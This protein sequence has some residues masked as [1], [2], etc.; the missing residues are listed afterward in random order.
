MSH[1]YSDTFFDYIDASARASATHVTTLLYP[2][3]RPASVIDMG[4]GR[5]V[6]L[7]A[8]RRAGANEVLG[9]DGD[10]VD[11]RTLEI[12]RD[13]FL[14]A[15]LTQP[16]RTGRRFDLAQSL[17]VGEHLPACAAETLVESLTTASDRVLFSA[18]VVGQ[19]GEFHINEQPLS[20]WQ[21]LFDARGYRA[22]DCL[23]PHLQH[24]RSV[25]PWYR[26]NSVLYVNDAGRQGL[27]DAVQRYQV[28]A[29]AA[30]KTGGDALWRLRCA[31]LGRLP[32]PAVTRMAQLRAALLALKARSAA[33]GDL[34]AWP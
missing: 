29:G 11:P 27:A 22:Y 8:W 34:S 12:E 18:A 4:C 21:G 1:I 20:Y 9:A 13:A 32:Q 7:D 6:W 2:M 5:G 26:Y 10:Y 15:D 19:G 17:E 23:R 28:P 30:V 14:P 33:R 24:A 16:L 25:A 31:V 3:L